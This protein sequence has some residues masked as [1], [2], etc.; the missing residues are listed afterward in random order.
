[1]SE[2]YQPYKSSNEQGSN[3]LRENTGANS[4]QAYVPNGWGGQFEG[5]TFNER[6]TS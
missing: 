2:Q 1:M 3:D 5:N 6:K 4:T